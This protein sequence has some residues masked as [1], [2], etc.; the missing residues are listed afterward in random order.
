MSNDKIIVCDECKNEFFLKSVEIKE[1]AIEI[2]GQELLVTYFKCP[3]CGKLYRITVKDD[4]YFAFVE[5]LENTKKRIRR[6]KGKGNLYLQN[7]LVS[8]VYRKQERLQN[9]V[10]RLNAKYSGTFTEVSENGATT[11]KYLP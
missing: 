4:T 11:I 10:A 5:D 8:M 3:H 7:Q 1:S 2:S 9:H 6:A